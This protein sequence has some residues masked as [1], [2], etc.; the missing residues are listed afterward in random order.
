[1]QNGYFSEVSKNNKVTNIIILASGYSSAYISWTTVAHVDKALFI[2]LALFL[3]SFVHFT[4]RNS[5]NLL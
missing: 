1:M 5:F 3:F 4:S 2:L